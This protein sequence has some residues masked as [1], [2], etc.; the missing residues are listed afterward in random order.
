MK[1][2]KEE[3]QVW[4][5]QSYLEGRTQQTWEEE[6][7]RDLGGREEGEK[8]KGGQDQVWEETG[9]MYIER[10]RKLYRGV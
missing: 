5:P 10:V 7:R 9:E 4:M 1:L 2:K 6:G 3:N 8:K